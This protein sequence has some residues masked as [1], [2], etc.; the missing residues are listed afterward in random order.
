MRYLFRVEFEI[1]EDAYTGAI[2][3]IKAANVVAPHEEGAAAWADMVAKVSAKY[4]CV[5]WSLRQA[6]EIH[7]IVEFTSYG[8]EYHK[9]PSDKSGDPFG[10]IDPTPRGAPEAPH[11]A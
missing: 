10:F 1:D 6:A 3:P 2:S 7:T 8:G 4:G 11:G 5:G 9:S